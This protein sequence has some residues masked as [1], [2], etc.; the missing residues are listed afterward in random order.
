MPRWLY[1]VVPA[2]AGEDPEVLRTDGG[3]AEHDLRAERVPADDDL[4][5]VQTVQGA[6]FRPPQNHE[7]R[8][9]PRVHT[10]HFLS[11]DHYRG[12]GRC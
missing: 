12:S 5:S 3:V 7:V 10:S 8:D 9:T 2:R 1:K 4:P 6:A 11:D